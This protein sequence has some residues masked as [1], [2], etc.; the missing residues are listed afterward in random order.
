MI[1]V[2]GLFF[3]ALAVIGY[4]S[5]ALLGDD[6]AAESKPDAL[7]GLLFVLCLASVL[8]HRAPTRSDDCDE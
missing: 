1:T 6:R 3:L 7:D 8:S 4:A 5:D 2:V